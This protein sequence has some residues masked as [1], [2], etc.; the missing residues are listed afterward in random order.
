MIARV[1]CSA[2]G[3][4]TAD[5]NLGAGR[6]DQRVGHLS[7]RPPGGRRALDLDDAVARDDAGFLGRCVREHLADGDAGPG[8]N[9]FDH[10]ADAAVAPA[11]PAR[12]FRIAPRREQL[13]VGVI[14]L[15]HEPLRGLLVQ[16]AR[17]QG[18]DEAVVHQ[19]QHLIEDAGAIRIGARPQD[20]SAREQRDQDQRR[21][22]DGT[23]PGTT[24][25]WHSA[26]HSEW[27]ASLAR[28]SAASGPKMRPVQPR[29]PDRAATRY[30]ARAV[31][32]TRTDK[33]HTRRR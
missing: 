28:Y 24:E 20:K 3:S 1:K 21:D 18:V 9:V 31:Y 14:E 17:A 25:S 16:R 4:V 6:A 26:G 29:G 10:H 7:D 22:R 32:T 19:R 15:A 5:R 11:G 27:K 30:R 2:S 33:L 12:E 8:A 23:G 13:A